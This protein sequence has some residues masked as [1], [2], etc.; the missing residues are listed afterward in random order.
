MS[1]INA[2]WKV[3]VLWASVAGLVLFLITLFLSIGSTELRSNEAVFFVEGV[4]LIPVTTDEPALDDLTRYAQTGDS[5]SEESLLNS[6]RG[7]RVPSRT[8]VRFVS[9]GL[10]TSKVEILQGPH[11]GQIACVYSESVRFGKPSAEYTTLRAVGAVN[12]LPLAP[13]QAIA[14][15]FEMEYNVWDIPERVK[16]VDSFQTAPF[17]SSVKILE[18]GVSSSRIQLQ[19]DSANSVG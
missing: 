17:R 11:R 4:A 16:S 9:G 7:F 8:K 19:G 15:H 3:I 2:L 6:T 13:S 1:R 14:N 5:L 18:K 12:R 10:T